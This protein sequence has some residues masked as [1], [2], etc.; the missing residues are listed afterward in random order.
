[1]K[2]K[3]MQPVDSGPRRCRYILVATRELGRVTTP[4]KPRGT[5]IHHGWVAS[6]R[7]ATRVKPEQPRK[8]EFD[9]RDSSH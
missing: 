6:V 3:S 7:A 8:V 9:R 5:Q 2:G 1:V 4:P